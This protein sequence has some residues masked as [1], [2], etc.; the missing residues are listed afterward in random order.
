[1]ESVTA[2]SP[3]YSPT[4]TPS[5]AVT[6][7]TAAPGGAGAAAS[8]GAVSQVATA[9][10]SVESFSASI[11]GGLANDQL[12]KLAIALMILSALSGEQG[13]GGGGGGDQTMDMLL[14]AIMGQ[15]VA[16]QSGGL[17]LSVTST[18]SISV[19][20]TSSVASAQHAYSQGQPAP[21][22]PVG[23]GVDAVA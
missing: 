3:S 13:G 1:M 14:A 11:D 10:S 21:E 7:D 23:G 2:V 12:M 9:F 17:S 5:A 8:S 16:G 4:C 20:Q 19:E 6:S 22:A 15:A 18:T